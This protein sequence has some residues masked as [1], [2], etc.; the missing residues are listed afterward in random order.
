MSDDLPDWDDATETL[1]EEH[2]ERM[3]GLY[4]EHLAAELDRAEIELG[5][6]G[7]P[8]HADREADDLEE[9]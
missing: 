5:W 4:D 3:R 7:V 9:R 8:L 2:L 1:Y 6:G